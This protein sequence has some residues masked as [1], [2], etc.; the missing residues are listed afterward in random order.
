MIDDWSCRDQ[1]PILEEFGES[2]LFNV[3]K[4]CSLSDCL[5]DYLP[6]IHPASPLLDL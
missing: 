6:V 5:A 3:L 4:V 2:E 1:T